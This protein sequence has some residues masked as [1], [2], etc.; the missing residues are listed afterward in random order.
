MT[1]R[2]CEVENDD[3]KNRRNTFESMI[4]IGNSGE[5]LFL[6]IKCQCLKCAHYP[7]DFGCTKK[8]FDLSATEVNCACVYDASAACAVRAENSPLEIKWYVM[9]ITGCRNYLVSNTHATQQKSQK[10]IQMRDTIQSQLTTTTNI[11]KEIES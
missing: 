8:S 10:Y 5:C 4:L 9:I 1:F 6:K 2:K 11:H 3:K 7:P